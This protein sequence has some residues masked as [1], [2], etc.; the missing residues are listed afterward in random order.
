[1]GENNKIT[2]EGLA[3]VTT[4]TGA[5]GKGYL[6]I[7]LGY[8]SGVGKTFRMLDEAR[9]RSIR[10]QDVVIAAVQPR[11][12]P[13]SAA[14]LEQLQVVP[15]KKIGAG[16]VVDVEAVLQRQPEVCF[17]D[18]LAY[19]NP[20]GSANQT[21]WQD[22][23]QL[24]QAGIKVVASI[25]IQYIAELREEVERITG[26]RVPQTVPVAFIKSAD[27]IEIVDT[28]ALEAHRRSCEPSDEVEAPQRSLL[29]LRE[30]ALVLAAD[31]V[32]HQLAEYLTLH[33][34]R[35]DLATQE[36]ILV[37]LT[38]DSNAQAMIE[39]AQTIAK[40]FYGE[41]IVVN[42]DQPEIS[43]L[44]RAAVDEKL[45]LARGAGVRVEIL[46]GRDPIDTIVQFARSRAI[47][48][49]FVGHS[50]S[51]RVWSRMFGNSLDRLIR[52]SRG[53]DVRIF[54]NRT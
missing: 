37:C 18:G 8:A 38:G 36:R 2:T 35:Q 34:V 12:V 40:R 29:R 23:A 53:M 15:L 19:D 30:M 44:E 54:P 25:N 5:P 21:R 28:P 16:T 48:Q 4:F 31:V 7:F 9:R 33:G 52:Q 14:L 45:S 47:T 10:G 43:S 6:K 46:H 3:E 11:M 22:A 17:I 32:D 20:P 13:E 24:V 1:V 51:S 26:K 41:L 50:R 27:E 39:A 49:I 42:V